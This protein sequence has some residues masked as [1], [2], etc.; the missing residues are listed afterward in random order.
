MNKKKHYIWQLAS[1]L[2]SH[3]MTMSAEELAD[4]LNRNRFLT[5]YGAEYQ[6]GRG[7]YKLIKETWDWL[8]NQLSLPSEA[9]KVAEAFVKPDGT[10]AYN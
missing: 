5:S 3:G 8:H 2:S 7:T 9:K 6:G 1:F 10:Y 4:H